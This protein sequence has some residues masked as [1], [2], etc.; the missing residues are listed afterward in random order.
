VSWSKRFAESIVL[1]GGEKLATLREAIAHLGKV[2]PKAD[3]DMPAVMTASE[4]LT[5]AA[6]DSGP[7]EFARVATLKAINRHAIRTFNP[8]R[9]DPHWGKRKLKRDE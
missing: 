7:V 8:D 4:M 5:K 1:A 9:K 3:H 6:E 2:V